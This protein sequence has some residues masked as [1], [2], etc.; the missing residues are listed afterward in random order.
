[1][2]PT[3]LAVVGVSTIASCPRSSRRAAR[4]FTCTWTPPAASQAY[5]Q[6]SA[7]LTVPSRA[8]TDASPGGAAAIACSNAAASARVSAMM[9]SFRLPV[10]SIDTGVST[11]TQ[12]SLVV[13]VGP[14]SSGAPDDRAKSAGPAGIRRVR[15]NIS[16]S[17]PPPERSRSAT[18]ATMRF[19]SSRWVSCLPTWSLERSMISIPS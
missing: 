4:L 10:G 9:S 15:P 5:G 16:T 7:I 18:S 8:G 1:M 11:S 17:M 19:C 13:Y 2:A 6:T 14:E 3:E 12:P